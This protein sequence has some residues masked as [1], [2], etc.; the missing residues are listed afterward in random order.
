MIKN[1]LL[2]DVVA[3]RA[4][5]PQPEKVEY[6]GWKTVEEKDDYGAHRAF[7]RAVPRYEMHQAEAGLKPNVF[8]FLNKLTDSENYHIIWFC[9]EPEIKRTTLTVWLKRYGAR[10]DHREPLLL[11]PTTTEPGNMASWLPGALEE[12]LRESRRSNEVEVT[13]ISSTPLAISGIETQY[14]D[15]QQAALVAS[16]L[17]A[18]F[19]KAIA[20]MEQK[21]VT[22]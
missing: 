9:D 15:L 16:G 22:L 1:Y 14:T 4:E 20:D 2:L 18:P 10:T 12:V 5:P 21:G 7:N 17:P 19:F 6:M 3:I 11:R 8:Y 13:A